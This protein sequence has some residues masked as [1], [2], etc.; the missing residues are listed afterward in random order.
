MDLAAEPH[1]D[2][3]A[4]YLDT[5]APALGDKVA[6]RLRVPAGIG[7]TAAHV[8]AVGDGEPHYTVASVVAR[9]PGD[10]GATWWEGEV[11]AVNPVTPYRFL[12]ETAAGPRWVNG[13]GTYGHDVADRDDFVLSAA[14]DG[15]GGASP[16]WL[17]DAVGYQIFPDRF[18]RGS[19]PPEVP[20]PGWAIPCEWDDPVDP[21]WKTS[22]RQLYRGDLGGARE[23]L[24]HLARL[25]VD[26][27]YLNP[28][29]PGGS[30]HRYDAAT[31]DHVDPVL[32]GDAALVALADAAHARGMRVIGDL[33]TNHSGDH[34]DWF[35]RAQ[36][37]ATSEEASYYVFRRHPHDYVAWFDVPSLPKFDL[38]SAALRRRLVEGADSI[39]GRWLGGGEGEL[40]DGWRIDV[41]NM[42][43]RLGA[44]DVNHEVFRAAR[45][46]IAQVRPDAWLVGE[47]FYDAT[48]DLRG[49]GWHGVMAYS[50]FTRPVWSWLAQP[51]ARLAGI[52]GMLPQLGGDGLVAAQRGFTAGV[53]W[54]SVAASMT[55]L[56]SH[57]TARFASVAHSPGH[58][59]VAAGLLLTSVGVPTIFAGD[60]VGVTGADSD[61]GRAPFPW[62]EERWD[63]GLFDTFRALIALRRGSDALRRGGLRYVAAGPDAVAYLRETAGEQVLVLAASAPHEPLRVRAADV[64]PHRAAER[65]FGE[66][67]LALD[68]ATGEWVLP[69]DGPAFGTWR[70]G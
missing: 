36:A 20:T 48:G 54:R 55:L 70:L 12:L 61:L 23:R 14:H 30:S 17:A 41:G 38:R 25:G 6:V 67:E 32:G 26:L 57:D 58:H 29:F 45:R 24:D 47:H 37:D 42:T 13:R 46:T 40:L 68:A 3:S 35:R 69:A 39:L 8:R 11:T 16:E 56:D 9:E 64:G 31:F 60:E 49:D 15:L 59:R 22:V 5:G 51:T 7:V 63:R 1:H 19:T 52:P 50:W 10:D 33:T 34:H 62:N 27:V 4:R 43:G 21:E 28:V 66:A 65:L 18:A 53:P 2:G 44:V